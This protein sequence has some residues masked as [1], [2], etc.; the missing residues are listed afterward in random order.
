MEVIF[1][2]KHVRKSILNLLKYFFIQLF[3]IFNLIKKYFRIKNEY[4]E[5]SRILIKYFY[6]II[7]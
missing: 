1:P 2:F 4:I 7:N 6:E 3:L 5:I